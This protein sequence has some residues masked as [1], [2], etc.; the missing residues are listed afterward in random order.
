MVIQVKSGCRYNAIDGKRGTTGARESSCGWKYDRLVEQRISFSIKA[1]EMALKDPFAHGRR[2]S[3]RFAAAIDIK[4]S[5]ASR[6]RATGRNNGH[7]GTIGTGA[8]G[9]VWRR[10]GPR[11]RLHASTWRLY[12]CIAKRKPPKQA[13]ASIVLRIGHDWGRL[14]LSKSS[15]GCGA[16]A[17]GMGSNRH[18]C[19]SF[20]IFK[21]RRTTTEIAV[22]R[23]C[24]RFSRRVSHEI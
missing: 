21:H 1:V 2:R 19:V 4:S 24:S 6:P 8:D 11:W 23:E 10:C 13:C 17:T 7:F 12:K 3:A 14:L 18:F 22:E 20:V 5:R 16:C 9:R 15:T